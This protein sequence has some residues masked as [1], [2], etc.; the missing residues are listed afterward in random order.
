[1]GYIPAATTSAKKE[2]RPWTQPVF[3]S[4]FCDEWSERTPERG[5]WTS[6]TWRIRTSCLLAEKKCCTNTIPYCIITGKWS[7]LTRDRTFQTTYWYIKKKIVVRIFA[8]L[9]VI[10]YPASR[11][12]SLESLLTSTKSL[13]SLVCLVVG[14]WQKSDANN[15]VE[16]KSHEREKPL[17]A[18]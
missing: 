6:R 13:T 16:V 17:L 4:F 8:I 18:G 2:R 9:F 1:M 14:L 10:S 15:F 7:P 12:F 11:G 5:K 3:Q